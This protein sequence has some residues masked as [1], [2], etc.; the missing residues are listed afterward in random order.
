MAAERRWHVYWTNCDCSSDRFAR[1][2]RPRWTWGPRCQNCG[3]IL[4]LMEFGYLGH[5]QATGELE[6][7]RKEQAQR[8]AKAKQ[9]EVAASLQGSLTSK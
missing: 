3:K 5:V 8:I 1:R 6:A 4:W 2:R 7:L 9:A